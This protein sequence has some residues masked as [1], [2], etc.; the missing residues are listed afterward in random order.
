[1]PIL[2]LCLLPALVAPAPVPVVPVDY[3]AFRQDMK[4]AMR[5]ASA[6]YTAHTKAGKTRESFK[7]EMAPI[8]EPITAKAK[9]ASGELAAAC[10]VAEL[11]IRIGVHGDL[12]DVW[13]RVSTLVPAQSPAWQ[14]APDVATSL[15]EAFGEN[16]KAYV[17]LLKVKGHPEVRAA[18]L[19]ETLDE[20][21]EVAKLE[22][23]KVLAVRLKTEFPG[24]MATKKATETLAAELK[25]AVGQPAPAFELEDLDQPGQK[26]TLASFKGKYV[27]VDFWATW[28]G[29]CVKELPSTHKVYEAYKGKGLEILS[30]SADPKAELVATFRKKPGMPMPWKHGWLGVGAT[31]NAAV[32]AFGVS[33]FPSLFLIG[34]DGKIL[35]KGGSLREAGL[36]K[37]LAGILK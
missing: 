34:P 20:L 3:T 11:A 14:V 30:L 6:Q 24:T 27:L 1:M 10:L 8:L 21:I 16:A 18:F 35:A 22:E 31:Q 2:S 36:E 4:Q 37:T 33:G 26:L 17:E 12:G 7:P 5:T 15:S 29:W 32:T 28:C 13:Q 23:A 9:D 25:T 19:A